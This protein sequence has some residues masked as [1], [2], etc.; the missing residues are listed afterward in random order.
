MGVFLVPF[1]WAA[2]DA[3]LIIDLSRWQVVARAVQTVKNISIAV[4][5]PLDVGTDWFTFFESA[6]AS[7]TLGRYLKA[8]DIRLLQINHVTQEAMD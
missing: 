1:H 3:G 4:P 2:T 8:R 6:L 7:A 5:V